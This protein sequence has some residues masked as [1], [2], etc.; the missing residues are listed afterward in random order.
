[1]YRFG[2]RLPK[3]TAR[4]IGKIG[5]QTLAL[6][7][8]A[9]RDQVSLHM[10]VEIA[11]YE[12]EWFD[13]DDVQGY[14]E[15]KGVFIDPSATFVEAVLEVGEE[16][17]EARDAASSVAVGRTRG[18]TGTGRGIQDVSGLDTDAAGWDD[19]FA[20]TELTG[21]GFSDALTGSWMNFLQPGEAIRR[22][23]AA[24]AT[25]A[26]MSADV[27]STVQG[28]P[29]WNEDWMTAMDEA[30][31]LSLVP[32]TPRSARTKKVVIDVRKLIKGTCPAHFTQT[33]DAFAD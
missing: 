17:A 6:L 16:E 26:S 21:V 25:A 22:T 31:D 14:L 12:G 30:P 15:E 3:R 28:P 1:M 33:D 32:L 20:G 27:T 10:A 13:A 7:D 24:T 29:R 9:S 19:I 11:G 8:N 5:P 23:P 18:E 4:D 2:N